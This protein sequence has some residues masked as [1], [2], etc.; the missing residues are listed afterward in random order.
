[1]S[2][3]VIFGLGDYA[4]VASVYLRKDSPH[5]VVAF[6][7]NEKYIQDTVVLGIPVAPYENLAETHPPD[8]VRM[9]V[10]VGF[11]R[12]NKLRAE[13]YGDCVSRGYSCISYICSKATLM[14]D[15]EIGDN[16]FIFE[17]N[18][19]QPFASIGRNTVVWSGNHIGHH[20]GIGD[21]CF[22]A[23]HAVISGGV[24]IGPYTF[25]GVNAAIRDG[26]S[27]GPECIIGAGALVLEDTAAQSV[28]SAAGTSP[29]A[30]KSF[31]IRSFQ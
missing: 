3:V 31:E 16:T 29:D 24:S 13:I 25:I 17:N 1:M 9:L 30:R 7:A 8:K 12:V 21:H 6:T 27:V 20:A 4:R 28:Y 10:A 26:V 11:R 14:D 22:I 18:V 23:S 2:D 5:N 19:I 15:I